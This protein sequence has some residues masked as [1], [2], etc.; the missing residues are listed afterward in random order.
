MKK[1]FLGLLFLF[2]VIVRFYCL[3]RFPVGMSHDEI[4]YTLSSRTYF[5]SGVDLSN[6][7][8]PQSIFQ[9]KTEGIIS[10][11]A[12]L[13]LSP[14]FGR[15]NLN[16]FTVRLAYVIMNLL[17]A[18][19]FYLLVKK[20][21]NNKNLASLSAIIFLINP[22]GFYLSRTACD[23]AWSLLFYLGGIY[24]ILSDSKIKLTLSFCFFTL[25]FFSYGGAKLVLIPIV[26]ICLFYR[27][28]WSKIKLKF[29][30]AFLFFVGILAVFGFYFLGNFFFPESINQ[31]RSN[32]ILFLNKNLITKEVDI[33]RKASLEN[34]LRDIFTNK[35]TVSLKIFFQ[36]YLTAFSPEVLFISGDTRGTYRFGIHGLFFLIDFIFIFIGLINLFAKDAKKTS[37]LLLLV[38]ISPLSTAISTV[39]TSVINRS[40]LLLPLLVIFSSFGIFTAYQFLSK[41]IKPFLS[42]LILFLI[43]LISFINFLYFYFF[44]FP[45][46]GQENY[47]FSQHLI[48]SYISRNHNRKMVVV[49]QESRLVFLEAVFYSKN[50]DQNQ[51]L[52]DFVKNQKFTFDNVSFTKKCPESFDKDTVYIINRT[53][54]QCLPKNK[55]F[56]SINEEQFGGPLYYIMNDSLC[57]N[58]ELQPWLRFRFVKDYDLDNLNVSDFCR[59]WVKRL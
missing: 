52:K 47:F 34:P 53:K 26:L 16:Q 12:P 28:F 19:I 49:D 51:I 27:C 44:Q 37:F 15:I 7:P 45:V 1:V 59:T 18:L 38:L 2:L 50:G 42:F 57:S 43:I 5:L 31:S 56:L 10:F 39:E 11:L 22:W 8:F 33:G 24:F 35:I 17:T 41:K 9:T 40:F 46:I 25:G 48:G 23:T 3:D 29:R 4:E 14:Y 20:L 30:S 54:N 32:E 6:S 36:K 58:F 13:I 21:F 55:S